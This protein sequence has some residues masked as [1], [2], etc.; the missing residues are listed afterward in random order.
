MWS[1]AD[2]S[3]SQSAAKMHSLLVLVLILSLPLYQ[4]LS[5][6]I[7]LFRCLA[8]ISLELRNTGFQG[9]GHRASGSQI[10]NVSW[11]DSL[12][13]IDHKLNATK[14]NYY[15]KGLTY[16]WIV[17][18]NAHHIDAL[19]KSIEYACKIRSHI[20]YLIVLYM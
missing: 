11:F 17:I 6:F 14:I 16:G 9:A 19:M 7:W 8:F 1:S 20:E 5:D 4:F 10:S 13:G 18:N 15:R 2:S 3:L 12:N